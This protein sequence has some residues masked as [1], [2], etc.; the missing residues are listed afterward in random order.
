MPNSARTSLIQKQTHLRLLTM[1]LLATCLSFGCASSKNKWV[2]LRE[3]P[4]NPLTETLGL[5]TRSGPKPTERT[6]QLLRRYDLE[7]ELSADRATLLARLDEIDQ[8]EPNRVNAYALAELAYVGAKREEQSKHIDKALELYGSAVVHAYRYLFDTKYGDTANKYDPKFRRAC[9]LYNAALEG[10][11]RIVQSKGNLRPGTSQIIQTANHNCQLDIHLKSQDWHNGDFDHFEFVT[12]Y[13]VHGLR[14]HYHNFG[15]GV[16]LIAI[17]RRHEDEESHEE[18]YPADLS[19]PVTAFLRVKIDPATNKANGHAVLELYDPLSQPR[20]QVAGA[21]VPLETDLSTPL[22]HTLS[23]PALDD[24]HLSTIGLL[25]PEK[26]EALRGLYMLEPYR[27]EKIPVVMVHGLWSSPVTW[28]EM[29]NDL[30]SDPLVRQ[31]YQFWFY[32]YPT[33]QPFWF[34]AAE[35]REDLAHLRQ[36]VDPRGEQAALDQM[37]LVGHSMGGLVSKLQTVDSGNEFWKTLSDRPFTEVDADNEVREGLARTFFFDPNP[38][39][40]RV[41]TI[42]TPHRGS[43]FANGT[44]QWLGRKLIKIPSMIMQG[45]HQLVARNPD[46]FRPD[47]PLNVTTSIDSLVPE[48]PLLPVLLTAQTG[49]WVRYHNVVGDAPK[50]GIGDWLSR[51]RGDG[52]VSFASAQLE[53]AASQIVVEADHGN[54]HRHPQSILEVRR[55]LM[56]H[57]AELHTFP[58]NGGVQHAS[59]PVITEQPTVSTATRQPLATSVQ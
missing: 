11:L 12:D 58:Y 26:A 37:V 29:F 1:V 38:S 47:A 24:N 39:I 59:T 27:P 36:V 53:D 5:V 43:D 52:I 49:P 4:R 2:A 33:G 3:T 28:M 46:F 13:E 14:N 8:Q 10:T 42:G 40:R 54:V 51:G 19:F 18:F 22:A 55:I 35:M 6:I 23:Q 45:R 7:D 57:L 16:P 20:I 30:R 15:L 44:T 25:K 50:G 9:D 41:V 31:H 34:S 32:L 56:Q 48:S 21:K 17:H